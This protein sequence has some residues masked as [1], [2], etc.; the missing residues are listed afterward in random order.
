MLEILAEMANSLSKNSLEVNTKLG[1]LCTIQYFPS[2]EQ[3]VVPD[4][5]DGFS[6][7]LVRPAG[8]KDSRNVKFQQCPENGLRNDLK[9]YNEKD[10]SQAENKCCVSKGKSVIYG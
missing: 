8:Y 1:L 9:W 10:K 4:A 7:V 3:Y 2:Q 5:Y 6:V